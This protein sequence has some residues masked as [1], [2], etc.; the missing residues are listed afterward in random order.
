MLA[1]PGPE[2]VREPEEVLLVD[3]IQ[4]H[5]DR[6][7]DDLVLQRRNRQRAL[8]AVR[9]RYQPPTRRLRPIRPPMDPLVQVFDPVI[10]VCLVVLPSQPVRPGGGV[11][12]QSVERRPQQSGMVEE[13]G[14]RLLLPSRRS[15]PYAAQSL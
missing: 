1:A 8:A 4:H 14:E 10:E 9:L 6:A 12:P 3:R 13:R 15:F 7:L 5:H 11:F 2:P